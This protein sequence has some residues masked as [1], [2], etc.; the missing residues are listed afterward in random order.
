MVAF[1]HR[2]GLN[3]ILLCVVPY[4]PFLVSSKSLQIQRRFS[5]ICLLLLKC[6][7]RS[8]FSPLKKDGQTIK[9]VF[10]VPHAFKYD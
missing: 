2:S 1:A 3:V 8:I 5:R 9:G 10:I 7:K 6:K 4:L